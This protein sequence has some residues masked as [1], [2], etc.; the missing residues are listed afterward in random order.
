MLVLSNLKGGIQENFETKR[1]NK[2][3]EFWEGGGLPYNTLGTVAIGGS[4]EPGTISRGI[5]SPTM[6]NSRHRWSGCRHSCDMMK[7]ILRN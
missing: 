6:V 3:Q 4:C 2:D 1:Y 7:I 5:L